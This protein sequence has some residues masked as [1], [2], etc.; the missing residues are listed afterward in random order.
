MWRR[1]LTSLLAV[2]VLSPGLIPY[3][4]GSDCLCTEQACCRPAR[5]HTDPAASCHGRAPRDPSVLRCA[6]DLTTLAL[7]VVTTAPL[8]VRVVV[9]PG[10]AAEVCPSPMGSAP[11]DGFD[12]RR[13]PP[14][15]T[16]EA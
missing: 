1:V 9:A 16:L 8:P 13:G 6:H 7:H 12:A 15:R 10:T 4:A 14:P 11:R 3:V 2:V 5:R